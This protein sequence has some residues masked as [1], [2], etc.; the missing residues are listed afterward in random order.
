ME[1]ENKVQHDSDLALNKGHALARECHCYSF[2]KISCC[3][4]VHPSIHCFYR[5]RH[6]KQCALEA[7]ARS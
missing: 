6:S 1:Q 7:K 3:A 2:C 5:I 4:Q